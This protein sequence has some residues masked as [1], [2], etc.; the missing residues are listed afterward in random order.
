MVSVVQR[1]ETTQ[2]GKT[3][4]ETQ[5]EKNHVLVE[6]LHKHLDFEGLSRTA[7][8][9]FFEDLSSKQRTAFGKL[10]RRMFAEIAYPNAAKFFGS[11]KL[12]FQDKGK[13]NQ[14]HVVM[15][16]AE[17]IDEGMI[18]LEFFMRR[19]SGLWLVEDFALD[20]V[21]LRKDIER[22]IQVSLKKEGFEGVVRRFNRRL[23]NNE[24]Q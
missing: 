1:F 3:L 21:S 2:K 22:E 11:L 24:S 7:L 14:S 19:Q 17:H 4:A 5:R 23:E 9:R 13:K 10:L 6:D 20:G 16:T 15:V 8:G 18:E 12:S